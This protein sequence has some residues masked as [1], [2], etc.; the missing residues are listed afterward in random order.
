VTVRL[1][2]AN[3]LLDL[4]SCQ[5]IVHQEEEIDQSRSLRSLNSAQRR[6]QLAAFW[7]HIVWRVESYSILRV[8]SIE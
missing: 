8:C 3:Y 2:V 6:S 1:K 4:M 7:Q 5:T